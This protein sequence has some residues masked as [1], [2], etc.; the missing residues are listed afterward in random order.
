MVVGP[1]AYM[2]SE[3]HLQLGAGANRQ[4]ATAAQAS[5]ACAPAAPSLQARRAL[6]RRSQALR[7]RLRTY[8]RHT[9]CKKRQK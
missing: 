6:P 2:T 8:T 7:R 9:V 5:S 3:P 4:P 1:R